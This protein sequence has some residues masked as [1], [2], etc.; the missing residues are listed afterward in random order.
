MSSNSTRSVNIAADSVPSPVPGHASSPRLSELKDSD[1][2]LPRSS[3]YSGVH[4]SPFQR[5]HCLQE[6]VDTVLCLAIHSQ[7]YKVPSTTQPSSTNTHSSQPAGTST[8][9]ADD[10]CTSASNNS[11]SV[12]NGLIFSGSQDHDIR[13]WRGDLFECIAVLSGHVR[14]VFA[15]ELAS[16]ASL[17]SS[18]DSDS[19]S[20]AGNDDED[21]TLLFSCSMDN[22][23]RVWSV[24]SLRCMLTITGLSSTPYCMLPL[25][26]YLLVGCQNASVSA[27]PIQTIFAESNTDEVTAATVDLRART[28]ERSD[29]KELKD[30]IGYIY[31]IRALPDG[32]RFVTGSGDATIKVWDASTLHCIQTL[33]GHRNGVNF[34]CIQGHNRF[35]SGSRDGTI[36]VWALSAGSDTFQA[37]YHCVRTLPLGALSQDVTERYRSSSS[38]LARHYPR[39]Q[40]EVSAMTVVGEYLIA[41]STGGIIHVWDTHTFGCLFS[42]W[43][44][45]ASISPLTQSAVQHTHAAFGMRKADVP[46]VFAASGNLMYIGMT[47]AAIDVIEVDISGSYHA[48]LRD[49]MSTQ[50]PSAE[51]AGP[52]QKNQRQHQYQQ[53]QPQPQY[54]HQTQ[55]ESVSSLLSVLGLSEYVTLFERERIDMDALRLLDHSSLRELGIPMGPR[56]K[57]LH[58]VKTARRSPFKNDIVHTLKTFVGIRSVSSDPSMKEECWRAAQFLQSLLEQIGMETRMLQAKAG[59]NPIVLARMGGG[60][61][62]A[63]TTTSSGSGNSADQKTSLPGSTTTSRPKIVVYGHYDVVDVRGQNWAT[64]PFD[65]TGQNGYL[66]G[67]GSTDNKG[68]MLAM[69]FAVK[70]LIED[71]NGALPFEIVMVFEGEEETNSM[72]GGFREGLKQNM[73]WLS[74]P[75]P[76]VIVVANS[77]WLGKEQPCLVYGFRGVISMRMTVRG[78]KRDLHAGVHGGV[79]HEPMQDLIKIVAKLHTDDGTVAIPRFYD[80]VAP[81]TDEEKELYDRLNFDTAAY[82]RELGVSRLRDPDDY[83]NVLMRRWRHPTLTVHRIT[84]SSEASSVISHSVSCHLSIRVVP[85]QD[86]DD[87]LRRIVGFATDEFEAMNTANQLQLQL[88]SSSHWWLG[89]PTSRFFR[90]AGSA[91]EDVWGT[92]PMYIREG[93]TMPTSQCMAEVLDAPVIHIPFGQHSDQAHLEDERI[94]LKNLLNGKTVFKLFLQRLCQEEEQQQ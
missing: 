1:Q 33:K 25:G 64:P 23:I 12:V 37:R 62:D 82:A 21:D 26:S 53:H 59:K 77:Y 68:P 34:L 19:L 88:L 55:Y 17:A 15:L 92:A 90:A 9:H 40:C 65:L 66:Y 38:R 60:N 71:F 41:S 57:I 83:R 67:R 79:F 70:E 8:Q 46:M 36:K 43:L 84:S 14:S 75:K 13:V 20:D 28:N 29:M 86:L 31:C 76:D 11:T 56:G 50:F 94:R 51:S 87:V 5:L 78:P 2:V 49:I 91:I 61:A 42:G 80:A 16:R 48:H 58:A 10:T 24:S 72:Q 44:P 52:D 81:V 39:N 4:G 27:V 85:N 89:D 47:N 74:Q 3:Q 22:T 73:D 18:A 35:I 93:G 63:D 54:Q 69:I 7:E 6:H 45:A 32:T 30:H